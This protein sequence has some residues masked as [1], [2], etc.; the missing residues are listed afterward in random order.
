M[1]AHQR[2]KVE[3]LFAIADALLTIAGFEIAYAARVDLPFDH[4][5]FLTTNIH[6]LLLGFCAAVW[7]AP[8]IVL[9]D[10]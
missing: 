8:R 6:L 1:F 9:P 5:F 3:L 2:R 4:L 7:V 10:L